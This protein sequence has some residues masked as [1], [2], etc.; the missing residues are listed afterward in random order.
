MFFFFFLHC[1]FQHQ[2]KIRRL[3]FLW[4]WR[5]VVAIIWL[6]STFHRPKFFL[7][8]GPN[9]LVSCLLYFY[10]SL[11]FT[12]TNNVFH[13]KTSIKI[14]KKFEMHAQ[15]LVLKVKKIITLLLIMSC[16]PVFMQKTIK[17][18]WSNGASVSNQTKVIFDIFMIRERD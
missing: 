3:H 2:W 8:H 5:L 1:G 16:S 9:Q 6:L 10:F 11:S 15:L 18:E 4:I 13:I 12:F 7:P 17:I 14:E